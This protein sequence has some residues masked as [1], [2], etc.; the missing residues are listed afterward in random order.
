MAENA[1][2]LQRQEGAQEIINKAH[3]V[4]TS[5]GISLDNCVWDNGQE[6]VKRDKHILEISSGRKTMT[7]EFPDTWLAD[8]PGKAGTEKTDAL[9]RKM[10]RHLAV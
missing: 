6:L 9:L 3:E 2:E 8:Y 4:A 10:I 5:A 1:Y 7:G